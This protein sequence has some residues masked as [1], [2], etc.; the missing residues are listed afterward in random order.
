[1]DLK[2]TDFP[3]INKATKIVEK[4]NA[5]TMISTEHILTAN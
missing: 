4:R 1:M 3:N 2:V 5:F